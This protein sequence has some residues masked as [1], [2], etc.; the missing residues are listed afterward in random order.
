MYT[1]G[2]AHTCVHFSR[3]P[4]PDLPPHNPLPYFVLSSVLIE[5]LSHTWGWGT[6]S[7]TLEGPRG[8]VGAIIFSS[9]I[10]EAHPR[11]TAIDV[12][13]RVL[14]ECIDFLLRTNKIISKSFNIF[15]KVT[16]QTFQSSLWWKWFQAINKLFLIMILCMLCD[17]DVK[18]LL[19]HSQDR[20]FVA[21]I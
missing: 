19:W 11:G 14:L 7:P 16:L 3:S 12:A 8:T 18:A 2:P 1:T 21:I 9:D 4:F 6:G 5:V 17:K 10:C 15:S 13:V 20:N